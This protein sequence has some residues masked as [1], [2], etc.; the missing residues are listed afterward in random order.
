M[1]RPE[2]NM[3]NIGDTWLKPFRR[4][5]CAGRCARVSLW[6]RCHRLPGSLDG[7]CASFGLWNVVAKL[8]FTLFYSLVFM[9]ASTQLAQ[10]ELPWTFGIMGMASLH[11]Q[12]GFQLVL[13]AEWASGAV[14]IGRWREAGGRYLAVK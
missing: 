4:H 8:C 7:C 1:K 12:V 6:Q 10:F 5:G 2:K 13:F 9:A 11:R 14:P 3:L